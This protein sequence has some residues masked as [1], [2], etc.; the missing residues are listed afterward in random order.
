MKTAN[1]NVRIDPVIKKKAEDTFAVFGMNLSEAITIFLHTAIRRRGMPFDLIDPHPNKMLRDS[2]E[3]AEAM[4]AD[5]NLKGYATVEEM[6]AAM[7][8]EDA[9]EGEYV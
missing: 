5:P 9:E 1:Y 4:L 8:A 7:D 2:F 3:E 6:N